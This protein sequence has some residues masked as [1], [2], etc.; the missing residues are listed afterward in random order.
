MKSGEIRKRFLEY[1]RERG[2]RVVKSSSLIPDD[3]TLLLT[4]AGM[5]QFKPYFLGLERPEF[6]RATTCQKCVRTTD[7]EKVGHTARH[8]TFFEMLGNFSFGDY[9]KREAIPWA[10]EFLVGEMGLDPGRMYCSVFRD[11]DEAYEIWRDVVGIPEERLVRLGEEDNFW[12]MGTTGPCGPCSEII[13]DQGEGFGCGRPDCGVGC[14]CDRYLELWNLVFMQ[15]E[16]DEKGELHPLPSK[17]IDTGLGLERLASVL[18]GVPNNFE[19][20]TLAAVLQAVS[21]LSGVRYGA[22]EESD[23][24]LK[25]VA[26]H[27]RAFTFMVGDGVLPSNEDRGYILRRLIRRAVRHGRLLGIG[28]LFL[29]DL[30]DVVVETMGEAYPELVKNRAFIASIVRSEEERFTQTL[31]SGLAYFRQAVEELRERGGDTIPGEVAFH[32]HDTLGFP[33]ELTRELSRE[34]GLSLDEEGFAA[35]MEE[36]RERAR[37]ARVEEGYADQVQE[38]YGEVLDNYGETLFT[39]YE[40]MSDRARLVAVVKEGRA[41]AGA[42]EGEEVEF[43]L[44]RTPFYGEKGGQVGDRGVIRSES[45]EAE[46]VDTYHPA[47]GLTSHRVRIRRGSFSVDQAVEAEVDRER[48]LAIRRNHTAT[49]ILHYALREVLGEHAKQAGSLVEPHRL[50]FD[51]TH[52]APL[53]REELLR[54]EEMA[55][56]IIIEDYPVRAY[57]TTYDYAVSIDAVALFGE[58]YGDY[59]R[60]VE[61]DEIS[62][63]LCGGT[64]VART[65][66]IGFL[67][68]VSEGGIGANM[69]RIEALTGTAAYRFFRH[70]QDILEGMASSLRVEVERLPERVERLRERLRELENELRRR[71]REEVSS[72]AEGSGAWREEEVDGRR[73]L[74][75]EVPGLDAQGLRELAER[76]LSRRGAAAV[77]IASVK[78]DKV[79]LVVNLSRDLVEAGL[80]AVDLVRRG[81]SLLGGG[82][83]GRPDMAVG[84]GSRADRAE[85]ALRAVGEE[86]RRKLEGTHA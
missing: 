76:T 29:P 18:Q 39:G 37:A 21:A 14:D 74:W 80:N 72:L 30:V 35:L 12:D 8:L 50:R 48:R 56:R 75:A 64:H 38:I 82:G 11:D 22:A 1:F 81:A 16:R 85:E 62:R 13:Y 25:I 65:G 40:T 47:Q 3:P 49:H 55:N 43:F 4:N 68:V 52:Y 45:G 26:D 2:H 6:T 10:W 31:R 42:V 15:F 32:L 46:V 59:V 61:V 20:D 7:I 57:V 53:T 78:E 44:D 67:V 36:Q 60:V 71:E 73:Y 58:K 79:G 77:A 54:V 69:R 83:G 84:G 5:V 19:T 23:V 70:R 41:V 34:E 66:E 24:S 17:N 33:L 63:E 28:R 9:Y 27:S 51:F 86:I